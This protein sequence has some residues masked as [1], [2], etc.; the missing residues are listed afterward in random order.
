MGVILHYSFFIL[1]YFRLCR[2]SEDHL[3][4]DSKMLWVRVPPE[5]LIELKINDE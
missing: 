2:Q 5:V 1:N 4:L 3:G